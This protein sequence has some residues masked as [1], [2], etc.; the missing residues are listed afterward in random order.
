[1]TFK[2]NIIFQLD[3]NCGYAN[4]L[5]P[6]SLGLNCGIVTHCGNVHNAGNITDKPSYDAEES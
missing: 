1:M 6:S 5:Q 3:I 4:R 2:N